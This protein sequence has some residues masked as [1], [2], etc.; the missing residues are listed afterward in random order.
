MR[1]IQRGIATTIVLLLFLIGGVAITSGVFVFYQNQQKLKSINSFEDCAKYYPV[2]ESYPAQCN[3]KDGR[4]FVQELSE[5]EKKRLMTPFREK[6]KEGIKIDFKYGV[7]KGNELDTFNGVF[8]KDMVSDPSITTKIQL[9]DKELDSIYQEM[10]KI[11]FFDYPTH[12]SIQ[13]KEICGS[14]GCFAQGNLTPA[15]SYYFKVS[16]DSMIKELWWTDEIVG[17][18][19]QAEQL[20]GLIGLI[21]KIIES[22]D[23]YKQ[24]PT[25]K[26]G[27]L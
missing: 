17:D 4:H 23:E 15:A 27:Y 13:S 26:A 1:H 12:F 19:K 14:S 11:N 2:A 10:I 21:E 5:E 20:R 22:K 8:I 25:P 9:T 6:Q 16:Y 24:L 7:G 18:D 3:T